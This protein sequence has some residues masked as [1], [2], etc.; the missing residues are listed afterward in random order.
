MAMGW[1]EFEYAFDAEAK[2][3]TRET[4]GDEAVDPQADIA[5]REAE[6]LRARAIYFF[7]FLIVAAG[8]M[9]FFFSQR[10]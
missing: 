2:L 8:L 1:T 9:I 6:D 4:I 7:A 10:N 5:K 3:P